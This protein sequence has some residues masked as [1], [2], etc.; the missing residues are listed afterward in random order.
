MTDQD[1]KPKL[2]FL[3]SVQ[4]RSRIKKDSSTFISNWKIFDFSKVNKRYMLND[5]PKLRSF[6]LLTVLFVLS[7]FFSTELS[8]QS[9]ILHGKV[10]DSASSNPVTDATVNV[11]GSAVSVKTGTDGEF[12]IS[13]AVGQLPMPICP[14]KRSPN[15]QP[16]PVSSGALPQSR[17]KRHSIKSLPS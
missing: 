6:H 4:F 12:A 2:I 15:W 11:S 1:S 14:M 16:M 10:I 17:M 13:V 7:I 8:A 5:C 3:F 9:S